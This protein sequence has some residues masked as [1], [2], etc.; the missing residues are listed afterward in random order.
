MPFRIRKG[1]TRFS[2]MAVQPRGSSHSFKVFQPFARGVNFTATLERVSR[3]E[4]SPL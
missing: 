3:L 2:N 4:A 1:S